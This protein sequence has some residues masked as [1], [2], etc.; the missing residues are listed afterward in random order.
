M[1]NGDMQYEVA[2]VERGELG[3]QHWAFVEFERPDMLLF[4]VER[5]HTA[6][7][8]TEAWAAYRQMAS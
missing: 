3:R 7:D 8:L 6:E 1:Q 4:L 5:E 2:F